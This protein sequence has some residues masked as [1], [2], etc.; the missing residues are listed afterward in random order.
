MRLRGRA[1]AE[2]SGNLDGTPM[3]PESSPNTSD[4]DRKAV[5]PKGWIWPTVVSVLVGIALTLLIYPMPAP[6]RT[7][8][9]L[10]AVAGVLIVGG[11]V[12]LIVLIP[13]AG[14]NPEVKTEFYSARAAYLC[15]ITGL[16]VLGIIAIGAVFARVMLMFTGN[17]GSLGVH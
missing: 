15:V 3:A 14:S 11:L 1:M 5:R 6:A 12:T 2:I 8:V 16:V 10:A 4:A 9:A 7:F 13:A 17:A